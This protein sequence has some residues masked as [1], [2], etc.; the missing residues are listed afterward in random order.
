M[1]PDM[2]HQRVGHHSVLGQVEVPVTFSPQEA[3]GLMQEAGIV[4]AGGAGFPTY[5]KFQRTPQ[6][7]VVNAAES[8][9]GYY[10]DK[11]LLRDEPEAFVNLFEW[12][13]RTFSMDIMVL[14][15]EDVAKPYLKDLE[16]LARRL[17]NFSIAYIEPKY[18]FGQEK[19]LLRAVMGMEIP[20][21]DIPPAHGVIVSNV[22]S[23]FN[24]HR[25][26]FR[27]RPVIT[28]FLHLYGEPFPDV[29]AIEAP[30][31]TLAADLLEI[32]G[33]HAD[34]YSDC[35]LLD[36][37]PILAHEAANPMGPEPLVPVTKTTNAFLVVAPDKTKARN[38]NYPSPDY[39]HN[40]IDAPWAPKEIVGVEEDVMRVRVPITGMFL[41][42]GRVV[43][44][45]GARVEARDMLVEPPL[46]GLGVAT[47]ASIDG[48]VTKITPEWIE[49]VR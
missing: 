28:K 30:I 38:K 3:V 35:V 12:M 29:K 48:R 24:I 23:L 13:K 18:K 21:N 17:H 6:T 5:V 25:A 44:A 26:V 1:R 37:G 31:G 32:C 15:A 2:T 4:G 47:H 11:L 33:A 40:T 16:R 10:A 9:P 8:E 43:V 45:E 34:L 20:R 36:G 22:E 41:T 39:E 14:A 49:I 27:D 42:Q 7:L 19:A 46:N